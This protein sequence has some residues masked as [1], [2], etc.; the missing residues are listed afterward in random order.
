[1][2]LLSLAASE[3]FKMTT[4]DAASDENVS[5]MMTFLT[6][7]RLTSLMDDLATMELLQSCAKCQIYERETNMKEAQEF[8]SQN[9][10]LRKTLHVASHEF[11]KSGLGLHKIRWHIGIFLWVLV[12]D[13]GQL[14]GE[15][16]E[17]FLLRGHFS[18]E[19]YDKVQQALEEKNMDG[20]NP[21][22]SSDVKGIN[23]VDFCGSN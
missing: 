4:S 10:Y 18:L 13:E 12:R 3:V 17:A 9:H 14:V 6:Q 7:C 23:K 5:K 20:I 21:L 16:L 1:M 2:K 15:V 22:C 19:E 11:S 8:T